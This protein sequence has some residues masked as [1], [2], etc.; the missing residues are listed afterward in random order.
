MVTSDCLPCEE[1]SLLVC[2]DHN[3]SFSMSTRWDDIPENLRTSD[4]SS[5]FVPPDP[6]NA[7]DDICKKIPLTINLAIP[8]T[9]HNTN[10]RSTLSQLQSKHLKA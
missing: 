2:I 7:A 5:F 4:W 3:V 10:N 8:N 1:T 6:Q 9:K